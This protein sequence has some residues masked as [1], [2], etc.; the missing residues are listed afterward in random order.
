MEI[1]IL[2]T[3]K[4]SLIKTQSYPNF[5]KTRADP[6]PDRSSFTCARATLSR[7]PQQQETMIP[8]Q[9]LNTHCDEGHAR[10][11]SDSAAVPI[12]GVHENT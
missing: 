2:T 5:N 3:P 4:P 10:R 9:P 11:L 12:V 1:E 7:K 8:S 6:N